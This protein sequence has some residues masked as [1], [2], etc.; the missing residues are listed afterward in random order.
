MHSHISRTSHGTWTLSLHPARLHLA[1]PNVS[2]N[3]MQLSGNPPPPSPFSDLYRP[4]LSAL[5]AL[6]PRLCTTSNFFARSRLVSFF[7]EY[8]WGLREPRFANCNI[9]PEEGI[10]TRYLLRSSYQPLHL[11][12]IIDLHYI[13]R[14]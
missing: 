14:I 2:I 4:R 6:R 10:P 12:P 11:C 5:H 7:H 1:T 13:F 8:L 3:S 9:T